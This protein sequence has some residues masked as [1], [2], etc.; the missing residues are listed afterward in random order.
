[1]KLY[2]CPEC[3]RFGGEHEEWCS[4][5]RNWYPRWFTLF[6]RWLAITAAIIFVIFLL[7]GLLSGCS[8]AN[9]ATYDQLYVIGD[10]LSME[11]SGAPYPNLYYGNGTSNGPMWP[12]YLASSLGID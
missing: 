10:S 8:S 2:L 12:E 11:N 5:G 6:C 4:I 1:M 9:A 3:N 7:I